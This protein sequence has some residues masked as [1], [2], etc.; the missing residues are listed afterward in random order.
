M[1]TCG[2]FGRDLAG[3]TGGAVTI[4]HKAVL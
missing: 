4:G 1:A 2:G 3:L